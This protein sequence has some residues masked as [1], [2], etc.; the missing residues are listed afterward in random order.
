MNTNIKNGFAPIPGKGKPVGYECLNCKK[1][2]LYWK[3]LLEIVSSKPKCP[4]CGSKNV[5]K[6]N[7]LIVM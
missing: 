2:F 5:R 7:D 3:N 6:T 1:K 4:H